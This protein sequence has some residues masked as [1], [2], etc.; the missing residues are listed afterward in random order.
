[1]SRVR[2]SASDVARPAVA[3]LSITA[4]SHG[5]FAAPAFGLADSC[6]AAVSGLV[7]SYTADLKASDG[8]ES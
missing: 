2:S 8:N 4:L 7:E 6:N 1:M 3:Y 5:L